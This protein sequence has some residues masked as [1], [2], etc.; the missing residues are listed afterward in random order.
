MNSN[1]ENAIMSRRDEMLAFIRVY[2]PE[3]AETLSKL[4]QKERALAEGNVYGER[5]TS[6]QFA[7]VFDPLLTQAF[8]RSQILEHLAKK[9]ASVPC[10]AK[11]L[12][13]LSNI[14]FDHVKELLRRDLVEIAGYDDRDAIYRRKSPGT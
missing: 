13:M 5:F 14:V 10:L 2:D 7:L 9:N 8:E 12:K 11:A 6:R 3:G 4:K 1:N